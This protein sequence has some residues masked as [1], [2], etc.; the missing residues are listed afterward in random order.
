MTRISECRYVNVEV[1]VIWSNLREVLQDDSGWSE[2]YLHSLTL[3]HLP[4]KNVLYILLLHQEPIT[5]PN[6]RLQQHTDGEGQVVFK[7]MIR[8]YKI[9]NIGAIFR[10]HLFGKSFSMQ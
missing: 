1:T 5:I 3:C 7:K 10:L 2:R 4:V 9:S 8:G 6:G